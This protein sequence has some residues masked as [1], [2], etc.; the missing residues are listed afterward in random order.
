MRNI[1]IEIVTVFKRPTDN[2]GGSDLHLHTSIAIEYE[3]EINNKI[4]N[5]SFLPIQSDTHRSEYFS[6]D[7]KTTNHFIKSTE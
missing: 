7:L 4:I 6:G 1:R 3:R 2:A 5:D